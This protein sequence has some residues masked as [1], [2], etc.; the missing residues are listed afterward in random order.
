[1]HHSGNVV[2]KL[3]ME[4]KLKNDITKA[5][6]D[7]VE[8]V[9]QVGIDLKFWN[10]FLQTSVRKFQAENIEAREIV[11]SLFGAYD[12]DV[13]SDSGYLKIYDKSKS[14]GSA[15]LE[16][17]RVKFFSW[18][19]NGG[20]VRVYVAIEIVLIQTIWDNYFSTLPNPTASKKN[21]DTIQRKI[22]E[23]LKEKSRSGETKNNRHL[24][25]YLSLNSIEYQKF[26]AKPIRIDLTTTWKDFFELVSILRNIV[27][28]VGSKVNNDLLN[29]IRSKAK[30]IFERHFIIIMDGQNEQHLMAVQ[31]Q[32]GNF[33]NLINDFTLNTI[34]IARKETNFDFLKMNKTY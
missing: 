11:S 32:I 7:Y 23:K 2:S 34:K 8:A 26:L 13:S 33:L 14:I 1:M 6:H 27:S 4:P 24:V 22:R 5:Y 29:E 10:R 12:I 15:E 9:F 30:D 17:Y 21:T 20:I 19:I 25:E 3:K 28:H 18:V 31:D 16:A